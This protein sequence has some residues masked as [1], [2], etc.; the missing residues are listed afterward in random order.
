MVHLE[1]QGHEVQAGGGWRRKQVSICVE[2]KYIYLYTACDRTCNN[3]TVLCTVE[4]RL[5]EMI[6]TV[7]TSYDDIMY[8]SYV[9]WNNLVEGAAIPHIWSLARSCLA[10]YIHGNLYY[11]T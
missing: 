8:S 1:G 11:S 2:T 5:F 3:L 10:G 7:R 9:S 6:S 4:L